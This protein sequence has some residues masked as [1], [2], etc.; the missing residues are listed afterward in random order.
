MITLEN[1][2]TYAELKGFESQRHLVESSS[3]CT[4]EI[5]G[6]QVKGQHVWHWFKQTTFKATETREARVFLS[7]DHSYSM[8]TGKSKRGLMH[9]IRIESKVKDFLAKVAA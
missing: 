5:V 8:N 1:I 7:F 3:Y 2:L 9:R 6:F 4:E